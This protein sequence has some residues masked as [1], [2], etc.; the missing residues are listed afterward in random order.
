MPAFSSPRLR[1][2]SP[3]SAI[4]TGDC[5]CVRGC[6]VRNRSAG[7][8]LR[9]TTCHCAL[10]PPGRRSSATSSISSANSFLLNLL[11]SWYS[12]PHHLEASQSSDTRN[13]T[14]SQRPRPPLAGDEAVVRVQIEE[15]VFGSAPAFADH[16]VAQRYS[17][18]VVPAGMTDEQP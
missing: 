14:A 17:P 9:R 8:P 13:R 11:A 4:A 2:L 10:R 12:S 18:I 6:T 16:P 7:S 3:A 1:L 15:N 5:C